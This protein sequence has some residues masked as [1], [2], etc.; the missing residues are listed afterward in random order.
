MRI[1]APTLE[2]LLD[3]VAE[4][5]GL[6]SLV[7]THRTRQYAHARQEFYWIAHHLIGASLGQ[8]GRAIARDHTTVLHGLR[9]VDH[10]R[11]TDLTYADDLARREADIVPWIKAEFIRHGG[12]AAPEFRRRVA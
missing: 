10:R 2:Y 3:A 11:A 4:A 8:I 1:V 12:G 6:T 9:M 7:T 5:H